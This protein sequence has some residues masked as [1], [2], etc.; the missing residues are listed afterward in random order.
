VVRNALAFILGFSLVFVALGASFSYLGQLLF[1]YQDVVRQ[2]GGLLIILFGV[3]IAGVLRLPWLARERRFQLTGQQG[4]AVG[5]AVV[6][7][8]FGAAWTPCVGP[9]LGSIL[10]LATTTDSTLAG[11]KLLMAYSAGLAV[12]FLVAALAVERWLRFADRFKR[13]LPLVD[14]VAG[15]IL[16]IMGILV[17]TNYVSVLNTYF[18]Q[19]TPEWLWRRL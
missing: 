15:V 9:I 7:V 3:Y 16:V 10:L 17:V 6:G 1:R 11:V 18:I 8:T 4:K 2:M 12:P 14:K 19:L 13:W 5:A